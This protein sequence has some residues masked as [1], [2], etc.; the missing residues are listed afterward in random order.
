MISYVTYRGNTT[1]YGSDPNCKCG[2]KAVKYVSSICT[3]FNYVHTGEQFRRTV[4]I[5]ENSSTLVPNPGKASVGSSSG[6]K[7]AKA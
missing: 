5:R 7:I 6:L 2:S 1:G 3:N 4:Q